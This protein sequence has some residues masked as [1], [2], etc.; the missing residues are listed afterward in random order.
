MYDAATP[1]SF[2]EHEPHVLNL[3]EAWKTGYRKVLPLSQ[4][5][6]AEIPTFLMLRRLLLVA[7]IASHSETNQARLMG[8]RYTEDTVSLCDAYLTSFD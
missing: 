6:E 3:I 2:Y 8:P 5:D 4:E 1:V 7:W